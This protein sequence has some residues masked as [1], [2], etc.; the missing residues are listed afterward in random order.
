MRCIANKEYMLS[1]KTSHRTA[2]LLYRQLWRTAM[3]LLRLNHRLADGY[4]GR[5]K[6]E[7]R[8]HDADLWIQAASA[9]ESY[10][11]CHLMDTLSP[12]APL[13]VLVTTNTRQGMDILKA[14]RAKGGGENVRVNFAFFPF[15]HP[16]IMAK[17]LARANP[18]LLI[19][20]ETE[21][22]P[23]LLAALKSHARCKSI[24]INGR[25]SP[26]SFR[27]YRLWPSFCHA[28]RPD[29]IQA[30]T[31]AD[32]DH[33]ATVFGMDDIEVVSNI[34]F[35]RIH[36]APGATENPLGRYI[37]PQTAFCVLGS[38]RQEEES[39]VL[40][41]IR[42]LRHRWP[43][44]AIGLFP[45]HMHRIPYWRSTLKKDGIQFTLRSDAQGHFDSGTVVLWDVFGELRHAFDLAR[46]A[47]IGGSLAP[48]GG[49]NFLEAAASGI[50][51]VIGPHWRNFHWVGREIITSGLVY[52]GGDW[53]AVA[54]RLAADLE[55]PPHRH[56]I[57]QATASYVG[58]RQG[59]TLRAVKL[60]QKYLGQ[61]LL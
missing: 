35:D 55:N 9:G 4:G 10:L 16:A 45:R 24:I 20:L 31:P 8:H 38:V 50:V 54:D 13:H 33:F 28:L 32:A 53:Q 1:L 60:M 56:E 5:L 27:Y 36:L 2:L 29:D 48:L 6:L 14:W 19:M 41:I 25:M 3:P 30:I 39:D 43:G 49:Q 58:A 51:P 23:G 17:A 26:G 40:E 61:T 18:R 15:D 52:Q 37:K 57:R 7:H 34:K 47:F 11:A 59:G 44:V 46:T 22:W 21:I 42:R 12:E